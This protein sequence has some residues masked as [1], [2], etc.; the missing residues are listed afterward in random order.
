MMVCQKNLRYCASNCYTLVSVVLAVIHWYV[1]QY[2]H[3]SGTMS[4]LGFQAHF[5]HIYRC[6]SAV[7]SSCKKPTYSVKSHRPQLHSRLETIRFQES[8]H[9]CAHLNI[10]VDVSETVSH[11][12]SQTELRGKILGTAS[13]IWIVMC[14]LHFDKGIRPWLRW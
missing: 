1:I 12:W 5:E 13:R 11:P 2:R 3:R 6:L 9:R 7:L 4:S 8:R 10:H 14:T